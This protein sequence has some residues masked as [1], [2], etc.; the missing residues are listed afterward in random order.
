MTSRLD[1]PEARCPLIKAGPHGACHLPAL[2]VSLTE[3]GQRGACHLPV[4]CLILTEAGQ[5][6]ACQEGTIWHPAEDP[7]GHLIARWCTQ[8]LQKARG[9]ARPPS[10]ALRQARTKHCRAI[11]HPLTTSAAHARDLLETAA[12]LLHRLRLLVHPTSC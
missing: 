8:T 12:H 7:C 4:R 2:G 6:E 3:A 11:C 10:L 1:S 9:L 5:L